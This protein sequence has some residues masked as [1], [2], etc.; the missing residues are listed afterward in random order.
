MNGRPLSSRFPPVPRHSPPLPA[1]SWRS[2]HARK[3]GG[4]RSRSPS[5]YPHQDLF[6]AFFLSA[7]G[8][9]AGQRTRRGGPQIPRKLSGAK[10]NA[11]MDCRRR[12]Q[13]N[14]R[15]RESGLFSDDAEARFLNGFPGPRQRWL[16]GKHGRVSIAC[17]A[18]ISEHCRRRSSSALLRSMECAAS[19]CGCN[20]ARIRENRARGS[21]SP[22]SL[23]Y[24]PLYF[25]SN[26]TKMS[27]W[28]S[29][30]GAGGNCRRAS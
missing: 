26:Q 23:G 24:A 9:G 1:L 27:T 10:T 3:Q 17:R 5:K 15:H 28:F 25:A 30:E 7:E 2:G 6:V 4:N 11:S 20:E 21:A 29:R 16:P 18:A 12:G 22:A 8:Q 19:P 13:R 14:P